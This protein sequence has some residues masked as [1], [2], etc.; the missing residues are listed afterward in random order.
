[1]WGFL[2]NK[3][4]SCV[5]PLDA[6]AGGHT[7]HFKKNKLCIKGQK[8]DRGFSHFSIAATIG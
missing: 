6:E 3:E 2:L 5:H 7:L 1:L 8:K 4:K